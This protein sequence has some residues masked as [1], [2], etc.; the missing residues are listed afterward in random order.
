MKW[1]VVKN[2]KVLGFDDSYEDAIRVAK[3]IGAKVVPA[4]KLRQATL[5]GA[6]YNGWGRE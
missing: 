3:I 4:E 5:E 1:K 6:V 2:G